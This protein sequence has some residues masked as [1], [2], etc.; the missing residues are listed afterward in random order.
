MLGASV[1]AIGLFGTAEDFFDRSTNIRVAGWPT[2]GGGA[3]LFL[4]FLAAAAIG[5]LIYFFSASCPGSFWDW[6]S[7]WHG[8]HGVAGNVRHN[9]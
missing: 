9:R 8:I 2:I 3:V 6:H 1:S 4:A 7:R 5:Y